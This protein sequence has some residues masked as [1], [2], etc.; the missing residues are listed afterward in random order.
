MFDV[1][2]KDVT[3]SR[4]RSTCFHIYFR[5]LKLITRKKG[6]NRFNC[7]AIKN[8]FCTKSK[9]RYMSTVCTENIQL[10]KNESKYKQFFCQFYVSRIYNKMMNKL[11]TN[12]METKFKN[13]FARKIVS[14]KFDECL[15]IV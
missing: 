4:L 1:M 6:K 3:I 13:I 12:E 5:I 9:Y 8:L 11:N 2:I 14:I 7:D 10:L 15:P